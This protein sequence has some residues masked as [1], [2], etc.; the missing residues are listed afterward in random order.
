M[1]GDGIDGRKE[2]LVK[3][4]NGRA[5]GFKVRPIRPSTLILGRE[6]SPKE[7]RQTLF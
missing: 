7:F 6:R 1:L 3:N 2:K 4:P 5:T